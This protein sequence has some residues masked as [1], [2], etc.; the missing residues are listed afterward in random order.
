MQP[1]LIVAFDRLN[2]M[3]FLTKS[4]V[5]VARLNQNVNYPEP[6]PPLKITLSDLTSAQADYETAFHEAL[7]KD[8]TKVNHRNN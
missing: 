1:K 8:K 6:W 3:K 4:G 2:N 7:S 5:I